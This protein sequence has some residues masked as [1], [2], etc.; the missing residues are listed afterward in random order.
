MA[1]SSGVLQTISYILSQDERPVIEFGKELQNI[2]SLETLEILE[3]KKLICGRLDVEVDN[4]LYKGGSIVFG[5]ANRDKLRNF[6]IECYDQ[7]DVPYGKEKQ[8]RLV[9]EVVLKKASKLENDVVTITRADLTVHD[10]EHINLLLTI[11]DLVNDGFMVVENLNLPVYRNGEVRVKLM[12]GWMEIKDDNKQNLSSDVKT[13]NTPKFRF[14]NNVL[15]RD[16]SDKV[17]RFDRENSH[18]FQLIR[19]A[20][21]MPINERIDTILEKLDMTFRQIY[22]TA[23][24]V[25]EKIEVTFKIS[26][27]FEVDYKNRHIKR[28]VE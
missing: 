26:G 9:K 4:V 1:V 24:R 16:L 23:N 17:L 27:F 21:E 15:F 10:N 6:Y 25:N 18:E 11:Q 28:V 8:K 14:S 2:D 3:E 13:I 5:V 7:V 20:F 19:V 22:D 12:D